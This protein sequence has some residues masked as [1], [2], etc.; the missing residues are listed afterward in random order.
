[1]KVQHG[2]V[3]PEGIYTLENRGYTMLSPTIIV[4]HGNVDPEGIYT[5]ENRGVYY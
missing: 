5:L 1:M 3:D 2:S 4:Q